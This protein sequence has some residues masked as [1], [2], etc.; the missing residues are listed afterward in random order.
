MTVAWIRS[1]ADHSWVM[2]GLIG[3]ML[4]SMNLQDRVTAVMCALNERWLSRMTPRF[5][6]VGAEVTKALSTVID[7]SRMGDDL[8]GKKSSSVLSGFS[9][10]WLDAIH[11][12]MSARH[13]VI[14][15]STWVA[16]GGKERNS[17]VS[18]A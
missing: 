11:S 12:E 1:W 4:W 3:L 17:C 10:R 15:S 5:F 9:L 2:K 13:A 8:A 7:S 14:L 6:A 18:S 16:K